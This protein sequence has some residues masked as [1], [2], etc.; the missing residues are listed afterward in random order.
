[1]EYDPANKASSVTSISTTSSSLWD[2]LPSLY[3]GRAD[4]VSSAYDELEPFE[5][6]KAIVSVLNDS[7]NPTYLYDKQE[8]PVLMDQQSL[9]NSFLEEEKLL[10]LNEPSLH[11]HGKRPSE[12]DSKEPKKP[13]Q[14]DSRELLSEDQKRANHIAS[15]QKRRNIIRGGFRELTEIIP[16]LKNINNSKSTILFKSVDYIKQLDRRNK[17]LKEK[18][19]SL[20]HRA[21]QKAL[22]KSNPN[23]LMA[24]KHQ[25]ELL[26][27][28]LRLQQALLN[29]HNI[30]L[31]PTSHPTA[32]GGYHSISIPAMDDTPVTST[33][34]SPTL[35]HAS[36]P[37]NNHP[38]S[39]HAALVMPASL[40]EW[41]HAGISSFT[42]PAD[43]S[44]KQSTFRERLLSSGKLDHLRPSMHSTL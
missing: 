10:I 37:V 43:E 8:N 27:E 23:G 14:E 16:T 15:E 18:L 26:Q 42:I 24:H 3:T 21:Q 19:A 22:K 30:H 35:T 1:M 25:L 6:N 12:L 17:A 40:D 41:Q 31:Y 7:L 33:H 34:N 13:K 9:L 2:P 4:S 39:S 5:E 36:L 20:Q 32:T 28:Q 38:V 11:C 29:K 44:D